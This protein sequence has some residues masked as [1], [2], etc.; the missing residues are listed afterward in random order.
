MSITIKTKYNENKCKWNSDLSNL[1]KHI[2]TQCPLANIL[3]NFCGDGIKRIQS[4]KH[5]NIC[6]EKPV[7]CSLNCGEKD[8]YT[9]IF[10]QLVMSTCG[11]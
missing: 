7:A 6:P 8:Y 2:N 5:E 3:C 4:H 1:D 11:G 10:K 9:F